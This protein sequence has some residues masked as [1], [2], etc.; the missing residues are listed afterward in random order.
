MSYKN[1]L[2][3]VVCVIFL[4]PLL[5]VLGGK[6][7]CD[8]TDDT[9][10]EDV[11]TITDAELLPVTGVLLGGVDSGGEGYIEIGPVQCK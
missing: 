1:P 8:V 3:A 11:I 5:M 4:G 7:N 10:R 2:L 9:W 6:C